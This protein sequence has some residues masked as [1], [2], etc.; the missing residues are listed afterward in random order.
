MN[1]HSCYNRRQGIIN[2]LVVWWGWALFWFRLLIRFFIQGDVL[3]L[4]VVFFS[5]TSFALALAHH[6]YIRHRALGWF[7]ELSEWPVS[8]YRAVCD[9][10]CCMDM[11]GVQK[12][13]ANVLGEGGGHAFH[14]TQSKGAARPEHL[15][16]VA[17]LLCISDPKGTQW[18][19]AS[20]CF[21]LAA[22]RGD[23]ASSARDSSQMPYGVL[24]VGLGSS[25]GLLVL[26]STCC[27]RGMMPAQQCFWV[28][29]RFFTQAFLLHCPSAKVLCLVDIIVPPKT[30]LTYNI[31]KKC[32]W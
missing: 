18:V 10:Q 15:G 7:P 4:F 21:C 11:T 24:H 22:Q 25:G 26:R 1:K 13:C 14:W 9:C 3:L 28:E 5:S 20:F 6:A 8:P 31:L 29:Q 32:W 2:K 19:S 16:A 17:E 27:R 12:F 30:L 23:M